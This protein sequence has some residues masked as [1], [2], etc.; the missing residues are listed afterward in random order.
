MQEHRINVRFNTDDPEQKK[1]MEYLGGL[2]SS[3]NQFILSA[4]AEKI[5]AQEEESFL[6]DIRRT[7]REELQNL[8][9][10]P[11]ALPIGEPPQDT[12]PVD[13]QKNKELAIAAMAMF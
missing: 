9:I 12:K 11:T 8:T 6:E 10:V 7:I 2:S 1:I 13:E 3:R 4:I 5:K